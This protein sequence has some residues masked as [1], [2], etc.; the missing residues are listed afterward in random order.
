MGG[1]AG[2]LP[3]RRAALVGWEVGAQGAPDLRAG[4]A[5]RAFPRERLRAQAPRGVVWWR[6]SSRPRLPLSAHEPSRAT[7]LLIIKN[8]QRFGPASPRKTAL[9]AVESPELGQHSDYPTP[10]DDGALEDCQLQ[11][12]LHNFDALCE[13]D[14]CVFGRQTAVGTNDRN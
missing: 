1:R 9:G 5:K 4:G 3:P 14:N 7:P 12:L 13:P 8:L 10:T 6:G 11:R 2:W